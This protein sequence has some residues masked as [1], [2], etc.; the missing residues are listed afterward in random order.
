M[1]P[2]TQMTQQALNLHGVIGVNWRDVPATEICPGIRKRDLWRGAEGAKAQIVEI[3]AGATFPRLDVHSG[4]EEIFV[5][6]GVFGDG[7]RDYAAGSFIHNP[8][9][10]SHVPQSRDGCVIFVFSPQG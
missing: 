8:A 6:S 4:A 2:S 5:V 7:A 9:G 3:D 10:T 1:E